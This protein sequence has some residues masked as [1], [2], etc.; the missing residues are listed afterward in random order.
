MHYIVNSNGILCEKRNVAL[1]YVLGHTNVK[2]DISL[3]IAS[4][5]DDLLTL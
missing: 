5:S 4:K 3:R 1:Q 2:Q